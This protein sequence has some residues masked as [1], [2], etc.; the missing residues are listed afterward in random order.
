[1][2]TGN[3]QLTN[4]PAFHVATSRARDTVEFVTDD[5]HKLADQPQRTTSS[6][7]ATLDATAKQ[8]AHENVFARETDREHGDDHVTIAF[9]AIERVRELDRER[10]HEHRDE[11]NSGHGIDRETG[12]RR[13][14]KSRDRSAGRDASAGE[15]RSKGTDSDA[16]AS[17]STRLFANPNTIRSLNRSRRRPTSTWGCSLSH[18]ASGQ[19]TA[20]D[21]P[22]IAARFALVDHL[23]SRNG[24][25]KRPAPGAHLDQHPPDQLQALLAWGT[26]RHR[27]SKH[28]P[29]YLAEFSYRFHRRFSLREMFPR[30]AFVALRTPPMPYREFSIWLRIMHNQ[31]VDWRIT[32]PIRRC[33]TRNE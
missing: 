21:D 8:A 19:H 20:G 29:R 4:Q 14:G 5:A 26:Y 30:L 24:A 16:V 10:Q 13:G 12:E 3:S 25:D 28:L 11:R 6:R 31:D 2:P 17:A 22:T 33:K 9:S 27:S 15:S 18:L 23:F 7:L 1:M 32:L